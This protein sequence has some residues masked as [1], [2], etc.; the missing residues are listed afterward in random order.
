MKRSPITKQEF[1]AKAKKDMAKLKFAQRQIEIVSLMCETFY[2]LGIGEGMK[3]IEN[4]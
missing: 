4:N 3:V 2:Q 1:L